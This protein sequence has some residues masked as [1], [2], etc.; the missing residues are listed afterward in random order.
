MYA[1]PF[2]VSRLVKTEQMLKLDIETM[3]IEQMNVDLCDVSCIL[4]AGNDQG[5]DDFCHE[6]LYT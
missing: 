3:S 5:G 1:R 2:I 4:N 6:I